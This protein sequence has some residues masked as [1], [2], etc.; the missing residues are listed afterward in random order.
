MGVTKGARL[1]ADMTALTARVA[2]LEGL[3]VSLTRRLQRLEARVRK[4]EKVDEAE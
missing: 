3:N 4:L 1:P 2:E